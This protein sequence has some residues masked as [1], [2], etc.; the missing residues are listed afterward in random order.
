MNPCILIP[1]D[2]CFGSADFAL[3]PKYRVTGLT[4]RMDR[5]RFSVLLIVDSPFHGE[6][7]MRNHACIIFDDLRTAE[8]PFP[9]TNSMIEPV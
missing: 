9:T 8:T 4:I 5:V 7:W 3:L 6:V 1:S 2:G